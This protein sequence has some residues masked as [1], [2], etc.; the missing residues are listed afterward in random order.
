L[1]DVAMVG[2]L[3]NSELNWRV[4]AQA[5]LAEPLGRYEEAIRN[6]IGIREQRRLTSA[7]AESIAAC[8]SHHRDIS[9]NF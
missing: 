6:S 7:Q 4:R 2:A 3:Y 5:A 8:L 9:L 1:E